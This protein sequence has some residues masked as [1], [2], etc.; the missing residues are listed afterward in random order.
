M[1]PGLSPHSHCNYTPGVKPSSAVR[2]AYG[3]EKYLTLGVVLQQALLICSLFNMAILALWSQLHHLL[4]LAGTLPF[5][6]LQKYGSKCCRL[7]ETVVAHIQSRRQCHQCISLLSL[8]EI[9]LPSTA[10]IRAGQPEDIIEG[11][12][13]YLLLSL[14]ALWATALT[15]CLKRYLLAQARCSASNTPHASS[16]APRSSPCQRHNHNLPVTSWSTTE[17]LKGSLPEIEWQNGQSKLM[18]CGC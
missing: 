7:C 9:V 12:V 8:L 15:E 3:A 17:C 10:S 6:C 1:F 2:Q 14:P 11:A 13:R 4:R 18:L 16:L 5:R